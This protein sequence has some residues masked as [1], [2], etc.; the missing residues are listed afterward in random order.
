MDEEVQ[1]QSVDDTS[2]SSDTSTD[3]PFE[4]LSADEMR[5]TLIARDDERAAA[6]ATESATA[7]EEAEPTTPVAAQE[8]QPAPPT[9]APAEDWE[10]KFHSVAGN[11]KQLQEQNRQ[12][13]A[14]QQAQAQQL[15]AIQQQFEDAQAIQQLRAQVPPEFA[16]QAEAE[17]RQRKT[18]ERQVQQTVQGAEQYRQYL[19]SEYDQLT[20]QRQE[21]FR[22][23]LPQAMPDFAQFVAQATDAPAEPLQAILKTKAFQDTYRYVQDQNDLDLVG[24][25][26]ASVGEFLKT[27]DDGRKAANREAAS[28]TGRHRTE[29]GTGVAGGPSLQQKISGLKGAAWESYAQKVRETGVLS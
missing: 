18:A 29:T 7:D 25:V 6:P 22:M 28:A 9:P 26:L 4:Q 24:Q 13:L 11:N 21:L 17:Y 19:Q 23:Q 5:A 10:R 27:Q 1:P 12:L 15:A 3:V 2:T 8:T 14:A 20:A 16:D